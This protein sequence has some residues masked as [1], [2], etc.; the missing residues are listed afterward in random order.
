MTRSILPEETAG[1]WAERA[2]IVRSPYKKAKWGFMGSKL[3]KE[4]EVRNTYVKLQSS[5]S[6]LFLSTPHP[7]IS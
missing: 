1:R 5:I 2:V 7:L 6:H 3:L 4:M